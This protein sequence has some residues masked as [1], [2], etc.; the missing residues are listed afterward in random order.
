MPSTVFGGAVRLDISLPA[1]YREGGVRYPVLYA[2]QA[3]FLDGVHG[4]VTALSYAGVAPPMIV[5]SA[6]YDSAWF[7]L[8]GDERDPGGGRPDLVLRSI[9]DELVPFVEAR[10][11][12]VPYRVFLGHSAS[13]LF[14]LHA[15]LASP[16]L[17][18]AVLAAGPMFAEV[19]TARVM[20][21]LEKAI[22][23]RPARRQF[24]FYTQGDQPELTRDLAAFGAM[25]A[26]RRPAGLTWEFNPE[27]EANHGSLHIKTTYDG[28]RTLYADWATLPETVALRGAAAIRRYRKE[29]A[30]RFGYDIGLGRAATQRLRTMW[31]QEKKF[32]ALLALARFACD[33]QPKDFEAERE[34]AVAYEQAGRWSE[35]V[36]AWERCIAKARAGSPAEELARILPPLD[37]RLAAAR[38]RARDVPV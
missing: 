19:D 3:P 7:A 30:D 27:S 17:V 33:E 2:F 37:A 6:R 25:L 28:L 26:A 15:I 10:Y 11:R 18:Q 9:R 38:N 36:A 22:V 23:A 31:A 1:G 21:M 24:L 13:A 35:A 34:L 20:P 12:T 32:D 16:D 29:L 4:V 14:L 8:D 5:V